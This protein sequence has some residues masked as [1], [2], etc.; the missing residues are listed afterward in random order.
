[1]YK[2]KKKGIVGIV[3]TVIILILLVVFTNSN[4]NQMSYIENICN[5]F[6]MPVQKGFTYLKNKLSGNDAFFA[7]M[8]TLQAENEELKKKNSELEQSLRELEIIKAENETLKEYVNLKD[9]Y[10]DYNTMPADVI[11]RDISNYSSTIVINVGSDDGIKE[12]MTVIADSGLVGHIISVTN[13]TAQVQT[14][15]DTASAVTSTISTTEDTI[16][17]QGTLEDK[18]TLRATFI[19]TDAVVLEG[20]SIETSGIGGIYP[21]GIHIGTIRQ[22][23]NTSNITDRYAIVDT[24]VNFRRLNTVLVITDWQRIRIL[25]ALNYASEILDVQQAHLR[26]LRLFALLKF[27][28]LPIR[29]IK[30]TKN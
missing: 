11:N 16:V 29:G 1:M 22:V 23:V 8:D 6:V 15:V 4:T 26:F 25:S 27:N 19:P 20:D 13:D 18:T 30:E 17:V 10:K 9:K 7:D 24:A 2:N 12:N 3:I 14:I 5:V 21:K 28:S